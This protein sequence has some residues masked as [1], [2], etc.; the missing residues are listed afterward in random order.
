MRFD[1]SVNIF[2]DRMLLNR[3]EQERIKLLNY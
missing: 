3:R 2:T 1:Y